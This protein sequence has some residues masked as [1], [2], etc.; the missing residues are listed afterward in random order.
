V[1]VAAM[2]I[3]APIAPPARRRR[4]RPAWCALFLEHME[5][6]NN[7]AKSADLAGCKDRSEVY[8][9]ARRHP[10]FAREWAEA[11]AVFV[12]M[13]RRSRRRSGSSD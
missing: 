10:E 2:T 5:R 1:S 13:Y 7:V 4:C 3:E 9:Y 11:Q 12:V 8:R 6:T